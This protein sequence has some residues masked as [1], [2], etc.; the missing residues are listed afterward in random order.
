[1]YLRTDANDIRTG[2]VAQDVQSALQASSLPDR[3]VIRSK[4]TSVYGA[5]QYEFLTS[6]RYERLAP[7]LLGAVEELANRITQLEPQQQYM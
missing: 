4:I 5:G 3:P 6:L 2:L 7:M 1:M